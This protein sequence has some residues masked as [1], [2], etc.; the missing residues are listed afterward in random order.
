MTVQFKEETYGPEALSLTGLA[1]KLTSFNWFGEIGTVD[2]AVEKHVRQF[3]EA[4]D[5]S[6]YNIKWVAK[7]DIATT[8]GEL[9]FENSD[10]WRALKGIPERYNQLIT[11]KDRTALLESV[12]DAIPEAVFHP[13]YAGAF[14]Q[15][16]ED[17]AI[18]Y[19]V[20]NAMYISVM[21]CTA[22]LADRP[23]MF[24]PLLNIVEKG[25]TVLGL[26]GN[27]IYII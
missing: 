18:S 19:L 26:E 27:T 1:K 15:V 17:K 24:Q 21:A 2:T 22:S 9:T 12:I 23:K 13:A 20:G 3:I 11:E 4:L 14:K 6:Q 10:V 25:H 5:V 16:T 8:I 7:E